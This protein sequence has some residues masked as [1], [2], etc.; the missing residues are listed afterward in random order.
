M[1]EAGKKSLTCWFLCRWVC[2]LFDRSDLKLCLEPLK[3][4]PAESEV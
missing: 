2:I 3:Y 1:L 4:T